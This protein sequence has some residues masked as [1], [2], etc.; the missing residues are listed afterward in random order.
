[1]DRQMISGL[2]A[3]AII[4]IMPITIETVILK[5]Y[6]KKNWIKSFLYSIIAKS[7][8]TL[9]LAAFFYLIYSIETID[10]KVVLLYVVAVPTI[11][12]V[13]ETKILRV[14]WKNIARKK[15]FSPVLAANLIIFIFFMIVLAFL[16][17]LGSAKERARRIAC[18]SNL[19]QIGI[20]LVQY[21]DDN[22]GFFPDKSGAEGFEQLRVGDYLTDY[23]VYRCP[24]SKTQ[25]GENNQKLSEENVSY[26]YKGGLKCSQA[27]D[28]GTAIVWDKLENHRD[29]GNVL[30]NDGQVK[31]F[32]YEDWMENAGIEKD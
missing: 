15:I 27:E 32:S 14:L 18:N 12:L 28:L 20:A 17:P 2:L 1:M 21:A 5:I 3:I 10:Y 6:I 11:V 13:L 23:S 24:S 8:S 4:I 30:F 22:D 25:K 7:T 19:R 16:P 26:I 29:Y 9:G 31:S